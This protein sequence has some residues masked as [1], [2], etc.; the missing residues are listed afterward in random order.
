MNNNY[1]IIGLINLCEIYDITL[2]QLTYS[3]LQ[4]QLNKKCLIAEILTQAI[5][6]RSY[7]NKIKLTTNDSIFFWHLTPLINYGSNETN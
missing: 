3:N 2:Y 5:R 1:A 7:A 4:I 6:H